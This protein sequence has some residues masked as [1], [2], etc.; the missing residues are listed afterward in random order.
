MNS[1]EKLV[2]LMRKEASNQIPNTIKKAE[3]TS[4]D[5]CI[6]GEL[7]LDRDDLIFLEHVK[8]LSEGDTVIVYRLDD[9][10]YVVLGKVV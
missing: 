1:Y 3:M 6:V 10:F 9:D 4:T 2:N 7:K 8:D 5:T